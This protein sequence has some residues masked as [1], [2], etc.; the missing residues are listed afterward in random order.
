MSDPGQEMKARAEEDGIEFYFAMFVD[1]H[2]KPCA[3][4]IPAAS[5]DPVLEQGAG[6]AGFAAGPMGQDPSDPDLAAIPDPASYTPVPWQPGLAVV[7]CDPHVN[8]EP[9]PYAPRVILKRQL[10]EL[11][12]RGLVLNTGVEAEYFLVRRTPT[13]IE[14]ADP[15]DVAAKPCYDVKGL[16]RMYEHLTSVS[17]YL[18]QL[19][20]GNYAND[21]EDAN[22]QFEQN[23]TYADALTTADR[24]IFYRYMV[25]TLAHNAGM[26]ATF[27]PKP[28]E[29]LTG[30]GLH[31][32]TSLWSDGESLF[33][34]DDDP[35]GLGLSAMAYHFMGGV[36]EHATSLCAL[37]CPTVNSYKRMGVGAPTSGATWAPAYAT[38]GGNNR[39]VMLRVPEPGRFENRGVDGAANPYLALAG[40]LA[41]GLDGVDAGKDPGEPMEE[42]LYTMD[43]AVLAARGI[44]SM[45]PTLSHAVDDLVGDRVLRRALGEVRGGD[46][47]DYYAAVKREEFR[48]YHAIVSSWEV[49][50]YLTLF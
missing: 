45:P 19:G 26:A 43:P 48:Q 44:R 29:H 39:T 38:Y 5:I 36:L 32:H 10:A 24:L 4:L 6:F 3:K 13:G 37:T 25:H 17:T 1:M 20:W 18:N 14:L 22:G 40:L 15:L 23:L 8:G 35:R 41:A 11:D 33:S 12:E 34:D 46:Y 50:R 47:I 7:M 30:N 27:M 28:F 9:W 42:N 21:H 2:G 16:G 31:V 49:E